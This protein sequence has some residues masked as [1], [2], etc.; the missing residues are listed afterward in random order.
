VTNTDVD[1]TDTLRFSLA[2]TSLVTQV[3]AVTDTYRPAALMLVSNL[4]KSGNIDKAVSDTYTLALAM[5]PGLIVAKSVD[6]TYT[7]VNTMAASSLATSDEKTVSDTYTLVLSDVPTV[8]SSS[9]NVGYTMYDN[10]TPVLDME[11][12]VVKAGEVE[13]IH[14]TLR[15][16][17]HINLTFH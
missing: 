8:N 4:I 5:S 1:T 11:A 7:L 6:D 15:P 13:R 16:Y 2:M 9:G 17:L 3:K 14:V 10:L 12:S